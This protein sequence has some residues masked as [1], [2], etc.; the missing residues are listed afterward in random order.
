M[1][2]TTAEVI[3]L[4]LAAVVAFMVAPCG[5]PEATVAVPTAEVA[6]ALGVVRPIDALAQVRELGPTVGFLA[7]VLVLAHLADVEGTFRWLGDRLANASAKPWSFGRS[8]RGD[9]SGQARRCSACS[10]WG[11]WSPESPRR[12][13]PRRPGC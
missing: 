12:G 2:G 1:T 10:C 13:A 8:V 5:L 11:L 6:V 4:L 3:A 9:S 7:A